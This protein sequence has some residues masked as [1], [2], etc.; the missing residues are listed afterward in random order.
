MKLIPETLNVRGTEILFHRFE[1]QDEKFMNTIE[2]N[3]KNYVLLLPQTP[4]RMDVL[5]GKTLI[6]IDA[7]GV[8]THV[9]KG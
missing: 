9:T 6:Y 1:I 8:V 3:F 2:E 5:K 7:A 4:L